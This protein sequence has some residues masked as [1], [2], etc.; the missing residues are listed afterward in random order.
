MSMNTLLQA[1]FTWNVHNKNIV[2]D[3]FKIGYSLLVIALIATAYYLSRELRV[4]GIYTIGELA[5]KIS[6]ALF[7]ITIAPG[8]FRRFSIRSSLISLIML[9]RR[10]L[11][12]STFAFAFYHYAAIRLF[13]ILF[14]GDPIMSIPLFEVFG[15]LSLYAMSL[16]FFTSNGWSV[17]HLGKWWGRIHML[18]YIIAWGIFSHVILQGI[19]FWSLLIGMFAS[20]ET[21]SLVYSYTIKRSIPEQNPPIAP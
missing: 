5:G 21:L 6:L 9:Y 8:I 1:L 2:I 7:C 18:I 13:P 20:L 19:S 12:I 10:H 17:Q 15:V 4:I 16:L 3:V 11:G 14:A